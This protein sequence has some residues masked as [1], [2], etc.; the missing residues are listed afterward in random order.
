[1]VAA[2]PTIIRFWQ[3][4][5][6]SGECWAWTGGRDKDGYGCIKLS[7]SRKQVG[8]H[9]YSYELFYGAIPDDA[10]ICH[11]CDN[12]GCVNPAHL[13]AGTH[14][15]NAEDK[16]ARGR[17]RNGYVDADSCKHGHIFDEANT[18]RNDGRRVCRA[19]SRRRT[20][21]YKRRRME[22]P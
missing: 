3:K 20:A 14:K 7:R 4:V 1:M 17:W 10:V 18:Y 6:T 19:C 13:Y 21:A 11:T 12:P 5:D 9:R 22:N 15:T 8:A 2:V 16:M